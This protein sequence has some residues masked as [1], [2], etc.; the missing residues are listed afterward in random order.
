MAEQ[1]DFFIDLPD[2]NRAAH[3]V[4]IPGLTVKIEGF[5]G[6]FTLKDL[7]EDGVGLYVLNESPFAE[8]KIYYMNLF[9]ID[10][11]LLQNIKIRCVRNLIRPGGRSS[12]GFYFETS[13]RQVQKNI[14][15]IVLQMQK[16]LINKDKQKKSRAL[17]EQKKIID[18][19][20]KETLRALEEEKAALNILK[21]ERLQ[22]EEKAALYAI[23]LE[24]RRI[25]N[26]KINAEQAKNQES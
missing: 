19:Q 23:E 17:I 13:D 12:S 21:A 20:K 9:Y 5:E 1:F 22:A 6:S 10:K 16:V 24:K 3:R 26:E 8:N 25:E 4:H 14:H 7:S 15:N 2:S 11:T 18:A